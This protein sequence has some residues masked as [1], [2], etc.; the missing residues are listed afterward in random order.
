M[1][2]IWLSPPHIGGKEQLYIN[3]AFK[4]NWIAPFGPNLTEFEQQ[5]SGYL[6][7]KT[8]GAFSSG[9]A[10]L[11]L[12]MEVLSVKR[13][14]IVLCQDLTFAA[15]AFPVVYAG[16][17]PVFIDSEMQTWNIDPALLEKAIADLAQRGKKPAAIIV[18]HLYGMP[19]MMQEILAIAGKYEIPVIEDAAEALGSVYFNKSCGSMGRLGILSFN[20]NKIITTGGG[21]A[22]ISNDESLIQR[23]SYLSNQAKENTPYYLHRSIGFNYRMSN[24]AAGIGRGQMEVI[25]ERVAKRRQIFDFYHDTLSDIRGVEFLEEPSGHY[26]NRWLTTILINPDETGGITNENIRQLLE[27]RNIESRLLWKPMHQQP[28][29]K[30]CTA[31]LNGCSELLFSRGLCLPSG[32]SL[33]R[34]QLHRIVGLIRGI[35]KNG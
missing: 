30:D 4:D 19:A 15:S 33:T 24:I 31:Y 18:V 3:E 9:T 12:A 16:A 26:S 22:L 10:A 17:E 8:A 34:S 2:K 27:K 35:L 25:G 14:D 13:G 20:G 5:L 28:V 7:V 32:S 23:A 21:G 1:K 29:F 6:N 11:H